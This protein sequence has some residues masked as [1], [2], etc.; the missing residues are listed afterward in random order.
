VIAVYAQEVHNLDDAPRRRLRR[1]QRAYTE[2]WI[3][4]LAARAPRRSRDELATAVHGVFGLINSVADHRRV[5]DDER[6][7]VMLRAMAVESL[8]AALGIRESGA[9]PYL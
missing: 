2:L 6:S 7:A 5:L 9:L 3:D 8:E 4:V 1:Q